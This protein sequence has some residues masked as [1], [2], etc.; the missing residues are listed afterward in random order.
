MLTFDADTAM[1]RVV[2]GGA[3]VE[4]PA[5]GRWDGSVRVAAAFIAGLASPRMLPPSE[6]VELRLE[7][8]RL[9]IGTLSARATW[10]PAPSQ[11]FQLPLD[12]TWLDLLRAT[13]TT[14]SDVLVAAGYA[15]MVRRATERRDRLVTRAAALLAPFGVSPADVRDLVDTCLLRGE[16]G[17]PAREA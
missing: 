4:L 17:G 1:L 5:T 12:A 3:E 6:A 10:E 2:V 9:R 13:L 15:R 11:T 14:S 7:D 8:G 16:P